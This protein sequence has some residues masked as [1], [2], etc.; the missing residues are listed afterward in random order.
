MKLNYLLRVFVVLTSLLYCVHVY[1]D[2][3][4][5]VNQWFDNMDY[6]SVTM[7]GVYEGQTARYYSGGG[8]STRAPVTEVFNFVD[9]QTPKFSAGCGGIDLYAGGFSAIDS[10]EFIDSLRNI[11]QNA[12]SL[13]FMLAIQIVSPQLSGVMEEVNGWAQKINQFSQ[14]SCSAART[15]VGGTME[16]FGAD[17]GNCTLKRMEETGETY[18]DANYFCTTGGGRNATEALGASPNLVAFVKG[19]L[20]WSVL[21]EDPLF[22]SDL[23]FAQLVLNLTGTIIISDSSGS[24]DSGVNIRFIEPTIDETGSFT[25]RGKNIYIGLLLGT[26]ATE[27]IKIYRCTGAVSNDP[28]DCI[29]MSNAPVDLV[30]SWQGIKDRVR[31]EILDI[32][33]KIYDDLP[34]TDVQKGIIST[35][36]IPLYKY[37]AA[38]AAYY[39]RGLNFSTVTNDYTDMISEDILIRNLSAVIEKTR[40]SISVMPNNMGASKVA[41]AYRD[42]VSG[43]LKGLNKIRDDKASDVDLFFAMQGRIQNYERAVMSRLSSGML[44]SSMWGR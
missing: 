22:S 11:G 28:D 6:S 38:T 37:L 17:E 13:A 29:T 3:G 30:A 10:D 35:T 12:Q 4:A 20:A 31:V 14:D 41:V 21:M 16:M 34:L 24:D 44:Q 23:E 1:S 26:D 25:Q 5:K 32:V 15:L 43:I 39:P 40:Q 19:N 7:P 9:I 8:I 2:V 36:R 33:D 18:T 42:K 27:A